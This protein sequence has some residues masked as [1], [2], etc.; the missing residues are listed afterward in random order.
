M[1]SVLADPDCY[2]GGAFYQ[3]IGEDFQHLER[4]R[5][6][7][8]A[9]VLD[10]WFDP[11]PG[12]LS[13]LID[14]LP[15]IVKTSPPTQAQG[16]IQTI[17][18][19]RGLPNDS[20][21]PGG[22]SSDLIFLALGR[23]LDRSSRVL[24]LDPMY[25]E[26]GHLL[27]RVIGCHVERLPLTREQGYTLD[28]HALAERLRE[29]FDA[30]LL[31][32]P[33]SPTGRFLPSADLAAVLAEAPRETMVWVD[34]TYL[35]YADEFDSLEL[36]ASGSQRLFVCTSMSKSYA[37]SGAR[38]AYL[39]GPPAIIRDLRRWTP[40]W[41][42]SHTAQIAACAALRD[43][44]YYRSRWQMTHVLRE[45]LASALTALGLDP[46]PGVANFILCHLRPSDP[47]AAE[48]IAA[49]KR[50]QLYLRDVTDMGQGWKDPVFR[51]AVKDAETNARMIA[52]IGEALINRS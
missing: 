40:P 21:L 15:W 38:C 22:G 43:L 25:G 6:I 39:V 27:R 51:I 10:A 8:N 18:T 29:G 48:L 46:V 31:V 32:N 35:N 14:H 34:E 17:A 23:L 45:G 9:D 44:D 24:I 42:V 28:P 49:C 13:E 7:I 41:A 37:L 4:A 36:A 26:Y 20:I 30:V 52:I 11:A 33:N 12:V 3:A 1:Q 16:M 47:T 19:V 5:E 2:H 50:K